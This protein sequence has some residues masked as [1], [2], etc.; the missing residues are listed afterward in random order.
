MMICPEFYMEQIK[1]SNLQQ[2]LKERNRLIRELR[3]FEKQKDSDEK[4]AIRMHP[5]PEVVYHFN[6]EYLIKVIE[7]INIKMKEEYFGEF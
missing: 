1:D 5:S 6:N 7:Q 4:E 3:K 2:L